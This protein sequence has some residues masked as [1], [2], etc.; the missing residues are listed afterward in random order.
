[1]AIIYFLTHSGSSYQRP[2]GKDLYQQGHIRPIRPIRGS[3]STSGRK[4][5]CNPIC[6]HDCFFDRELYELSEI[7]D[8]LT[9]C[10]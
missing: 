3:F 9:S 4:G 10:R 6:N 1:M 8:Y 7:E 2:S 5:H